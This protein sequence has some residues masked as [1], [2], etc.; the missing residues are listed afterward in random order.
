MLVRSQAKGGAGN[1]GEEGGGLILG[2]AW[3]MYSGRVMGEKS[4]GRKD[5]RGRQCALKSSRGKRGG[6][7]RCKG[8]E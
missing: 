2:L 5:A 3:P 8:E 4:R 6:K 1:W 7:D